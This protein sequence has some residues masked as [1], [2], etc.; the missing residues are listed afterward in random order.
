MSATLIRSIKATVLIYSN[1]TWRMRLMKFQIKRPKP[2]THSSY[3]KSAY[4][5]W[6]RVYPFVMWSS[7]VAPARI[8]N[9]WM[10]HTTALTHPGAI[11]THWNTMKIVPNKCRIL[12]LWINIFVKMIYSFCKSKLVCVWT[13]PTGSGLVN[14]GL[15]HTHTHIY[16]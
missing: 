1:W 14:Q 4:D 7:A 11:N 13:P 12:Y 9:S 5:L 3:S 2:T 8:N 15:R 10:I 6:S 16:L